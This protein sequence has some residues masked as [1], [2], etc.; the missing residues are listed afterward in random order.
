M[1]IT[2]F[3][4][5]SGSLQGEIRFLPDINKK[6]PENSSDGQYYFGYLFPGSRHRKN[7][8]AVIAI[9][10]YYRCATNHVYLYNSSSVFSYSLQIYKLFPDKPRKHAKSCKKLRSSLKSTL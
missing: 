9:G 4:S 2:C 1:L 7:R 5:A 10:D 8:H 3:S 6:P